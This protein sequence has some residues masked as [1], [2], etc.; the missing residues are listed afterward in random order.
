MI[1]ELTIAGKTERWPFGGE[2]VKAY[3]YKES[4]QN[5]SSDPKKRGK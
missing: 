2:S 5:P 1:E 4:V 3:S